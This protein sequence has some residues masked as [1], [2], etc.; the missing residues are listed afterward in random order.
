MLV[1]RSYTATEA[2][3]DLAAVVA[4]EVVGEPETSE[5]EID[6]S[7]YRHT[8]EAPVIHHAQLLTSEYCSFESLDT[9]VAT[10]DETGFVTR[11]TDGT[12]EILARGRRG[13]KRIALTVSQSNVTTNE[14]L[15]YLPGTLAKH[16][17][18]QIDSRLAGKSPSQRRIFSVA[19]TTTWTFQRDPNCW[20]ADIDLT[21]LCVTGNGGTL[22]TAS[23]V[24]FAEHYK[25]PVGATVRWVTADNITV[26]RTIAASIDIG[27]FSDI[28]IARLDSPVELSPAKLMPADFADYLPNVPFG[29]PPGQV[30]HA[31]PVINSDQEKKANVNEWFYASSSI[32]LYSGVLPMQRTAWYELPISGDSGSGVFSV[33]NGEL[34]LLTSFTG[35]SGGPNYAHWLDEINAALGDDGELSFCDLSGFPK[36]A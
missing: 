30:P 2:D 6:D 16:M 27:S 4:N 13:T 23:H 36:Y 35:P 29:W 26:A 33:V 9:D 20:A 17:T 22:I 15:G 10:V 28:T 11:V 21:P 12:A 25:L 31:V 1:L 24:V 5:I 7:L 19:N 8:V 32:G 18:D 34:V 14:W 3:F